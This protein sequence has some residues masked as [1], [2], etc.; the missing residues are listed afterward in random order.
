MAE[1]AAFHVQP[2]EHRGVEQLAGPVVGLG[3]LTGKPLALGGVGLL[4]L[5]DLSDHLLAQS[6][7]LVGITE[8]SP[9]SITEIPQGTSDVEGL[10]RAYTAVRDSPPLRAVL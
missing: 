7:G 3:Q 2:L 9:L 8:L 10:L 4:T 6:L 5:F 1:L